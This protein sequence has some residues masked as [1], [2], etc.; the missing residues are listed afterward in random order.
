MRG[1][2]AP[3]PGASPHALRYWLVP[4][5]QV[6]AV[7]H[8]HTPC[9][10]DSRTWPGILAAGVSRDLHL[11]FLFRARGRLTFR[12]APKPL[13][14]LNQTRASERGFRARGG[15]GRSLGVG[16]LVRG[17]G[18]AWD[19]VCAGSARGSVPHSAGPALGHLGRKG[20]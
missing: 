19:W 1:T 10:K 15:G 12:T 11:Q 5:G 16:N 9:G 2:R 3:L 4:E 7:P 17:K 8:T 14:E 20:L 6:R 18:G 13:R